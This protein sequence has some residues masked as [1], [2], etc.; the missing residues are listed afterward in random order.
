ME[1]SR[2][3][4]VWQKSPYSVLIFLVCINVAKFAISVWRFSPHCLVKF[5]IVYST[6]YKTVW[7]SIVWELLPYSYTHSKNIDKC[8]KYPQSARI[9]PNYHTKYGKNCH[10]ILFGYSW[11][12]HSISMYC[13]WIEWKTIFQSIFLLADIQSRTS[14]PIACMYM[15]THHK[16][17]LSHRTLSWKNIFH[18]QKHKNISGMLLYRYRNIFLRYELENFLSLYKIM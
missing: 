11:V 9:K 8:G 18:R 12:N 17:S 16:V 7:K 6:N 3:H 13:K 4:T 15:A 1:A 10:K 14:T 5:T 2:Y